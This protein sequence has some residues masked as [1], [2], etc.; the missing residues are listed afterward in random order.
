MWAWQRFFKLLAILIVCALPFVFW[1]APEPRTWIEKAVDREF[2]LYWLSGISRPSIERAWQKLRRQPTFLRYKVI[3]SKVYGQPSRIK[4]L[5]ERLIAEEPLPDLDFIYFYED[6][7]KKSHAQ[8]RSVFKNPV[9]IL[10]SA[11]DASLSQFILFSDWLYDPT[12]LDGGWNKA[13]REVNEQQA[14]WSWN[15]KADTLF[16][17]G[18]PFDGNHFGMYNFQNWPQIPRG[19]LVYQSRQTPDLIDAAFSSYPHQ[20]FVQDPDRCLQEMGPVSYVPMVDQLQYKYHLLIDGVTCTFPGTHWKLLSGSVP[21]KQESPDILYF[22]PELIAWEHYIPVRSD[23]SDLR[24]KIEWARAHD[25]E[26]QLI[27]QNAR[28]FALTHLMPEH[29]LA[30]CRA[31]LVRYASLQRFTPTLAPYDPTDPGRAY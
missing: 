29:I 18:S 25:L 5:L 7:I 2:S 17:R 10:V 30:Y 21:F 26:S 16:W 27:A 15:S 19:Q 20:C 9:P 23:L 24:L 4:T 8:R 6:R 31:I 12:D 14:K 3:Q 13:I 1:R 22:Y 28:E 11:K